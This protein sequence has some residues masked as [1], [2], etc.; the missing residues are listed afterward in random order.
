MDAL[1]GT[2][3]AHRIT[4]EDLC[5]VNAVFRSGKQKTESIF[6]WFILQSTA[7]TKANAYLK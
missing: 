4:V 1:S 7:N 3:V 5:I 6:S 2:N